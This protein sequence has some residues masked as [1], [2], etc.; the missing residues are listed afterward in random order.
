L[1]LLVGRP[2]ALTAALDKSEGEEAAREATEDEKFDEWSKKLAAGDYSDMDPVMHEAVTK[3]EDPNALWYSE[4]MQ[5]TLE[6][7]G[8]KQVTENSDGER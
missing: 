6:A 5:Q 8:I 7:L 1:S 2:D 3:P 4:E